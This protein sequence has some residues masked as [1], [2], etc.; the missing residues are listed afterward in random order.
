METKGHQEPLQDRGSPL[1]ASQ[2]E[3][4]GRLPGQQQPR[5]ACSPNLPSYA[6]SEKPSGLAPGS[7]ASRHTRAA[8]PLE[9]WAWKPCALTDILSVASH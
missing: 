2:C 9:S 5:L 6:S 8:W 7:A 3:G 1:A 4:G